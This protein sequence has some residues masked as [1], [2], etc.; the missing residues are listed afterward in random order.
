MNG[1]VTVLERSL[2]VE[3]QG[4][5]IVLGRWSSKFFEVFDK[6]ETEVA[7]PALRRQ[8]FNKDGTTMFEEKIKLGMTSWDKVPF[9]GL[10]VSS[11][12]FLSFLTQLYYTL[13]ANFDGHV[14]AGYLHDPSVV[15]QSDSKTHYHMGLTVVSHSYDTTLKKVEVMYRDKDGKEDHIQG[16]LFVCAE[17]ASSGSREVYFPKLPRSY[18]G[19]LAFRGL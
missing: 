19:Y 18:S 14:K 11:V 12:N 17:G 15:A 7:V 8:F 10:T 16:D 4:A 13:R 2:T 3:S 5:G 6:T 9:L 1:S